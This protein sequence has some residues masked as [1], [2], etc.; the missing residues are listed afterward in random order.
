[1][2]IYGSQKIFKQ[3][4]RRRGVYGNLGFFFF[5][6]IDAQKLL[7]CFSNWLGC[8]VHI[9]RKRVLKIMIRLFTSEA[10]LMSMTNASHH[11]L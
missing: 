5:G 7:R 6:S 11:N 4:G 3:L 1:M 10:R 8:I 2:A 9:I